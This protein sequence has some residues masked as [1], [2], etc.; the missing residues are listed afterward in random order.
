MD[1][2]EVSETVSG[3][4]LLYLFVTSV[5]TLLSIFS[6]LFLPQITFRAL[7]LCRYVYWIVLAALI[8]AALV[9][10]RKKHGQPVGPKL[11]DNETTCKTAGLLILADGVIG[12]STTLPSQIDSVITTPQFLWGNYGSDGALGNRYITVS[13][14]IDLFAVCQILLGLFIAKRHGKKGVE[15]PVEAPDITE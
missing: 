8:V 5:F 1:K 11:L 15:P 13:V 14:I 4:L 12:L 9:F 6:N 7:I 10:Y 3:I 2:N